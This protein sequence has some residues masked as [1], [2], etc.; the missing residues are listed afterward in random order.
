MSLHYIIDGYNIMKQVTHITGKKNMVERDD[1]LRFLETERPF[2]SLH[3]RVTIVFDGHPELTL[4]RR[5]SIL[6][7]IFSRDESADERIKKMVENSGEKNLVVVSDDNDV[8]YMAKINGARVL[9][10]IEFLVKKERRVPI[11]H[12]EEKK[13]SSDTPAG[14]RITRELERI[15]IKETNETKS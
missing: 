11:V 5:E 12:E 14:I 3:N 13:I 7:V 9:G 15:W 10:A 1:F 8:K 6:R 2:G 4:R